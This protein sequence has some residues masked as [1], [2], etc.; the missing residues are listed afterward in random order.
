MHVTPDQFISSC[1]PRETSFLIG[2]DLEAQRNKHRIGSFVSRSV[3]TQKPWLF[4]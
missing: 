3:R 1:I 2:V 4:L